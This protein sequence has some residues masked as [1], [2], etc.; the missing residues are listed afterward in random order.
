MIKHNLKIE[1]V[2]IGE[3]IDAE[4]NPRKATE[5]DFEDL[6][7]NL[8]KFGM[9]EPILVN[10]RKERKNVIIGGHFRVRCAKGIGMTRIPVI[11]LDLSDE[12]EKELNIRLN[13]NTGEFDK[14]ILRD[15]FYE[16]DLREWGFLDKDLKSIFEE[17]GGN[18][19]FYFED[20]K[21]LKMIGALAR[22]KKE[23]G[24]KSNEELFEDLLSR[25]VI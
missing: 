13:K 17:D 6:R 14:K 15:L 2:D 11:Y 10:K 16:K 7:A 4:Y 20:E 8:E 23:L 5:K 24:F 1:Y 19:V 25:Y 3:L 21:Y 9:L 18:L 12:D 22:A